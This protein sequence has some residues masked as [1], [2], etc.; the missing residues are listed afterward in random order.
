MDELIPIFLEYEEALASLESEQFDEALHG[1]R[2][3]GH[4]GRVK[5]SHTTKLLARCG[6]NSSAWEAVM[7]VMNQ[8]SQKRSSRK[9]I[10][11]GKEVAAAMSL[12]S[13]AQ[14]Q[15]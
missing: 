12:L 10:V 2:S 5:A 15:P 6:S 1:L 14:P 9:Q 4:H 7:L 8:V 13:E 11:A 3:L